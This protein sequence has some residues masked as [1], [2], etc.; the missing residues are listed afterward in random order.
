MQIN[1]SSTPYLPVPAAGRLGDSSGARAATGAE[2]A[3]ANADGGSGVSTYDF[4]RMTPREMK[5]VVSGLIK[6]GRL[7]LM[8]SA[9]LIIMA[10]APAKGGSPESAPTFDE[11]M[12]YMAQIKQLIE[13]HTNTGS[14]ENVA[15]W[16]R[17][18]G[19]LNQLQDSPSRAN[20]LV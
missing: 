18:L 2:P 14:S 9:G 4:T 12:N 3:T 8:D 5:A 7:S 10:P 16:N 13:Y 17:T 19:V 20:V 6:S 15:R 1:G 11:P